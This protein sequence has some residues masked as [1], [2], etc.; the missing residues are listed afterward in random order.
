MTSTTT[1]RLTVAGA[2][3]AAALGVPTQVFLKAFS[4]VGPA[5]A[6]PTQVQAIR[7]ALLR[8]LAPAPPPPRTVVPRTNGDF[9][10]VLYSRQRS[11]KNARARGEREA[12]GVRVVAGVELLG[13]QPAV[14]AVGRPIRRR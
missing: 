3:A 7:A 8:A 2:T 12:V 10:S 6:G 5:A 13:A 11:A 4:A 9:G 1:R 14:I